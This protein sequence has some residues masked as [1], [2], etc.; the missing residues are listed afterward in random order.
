MF[1]CFYVIFTQSQ[2]HGIYISKHI[3]LRT[4]NASEMRSQIAAADVVTFTTIFIIEKATTA[5]DDC[6]DYATCNMCD[7]NTSNTVSSSLSSPFWSQQRRHCC[8]SV[9]LVIVLIKVLAQICNV[10]TKKINKF[11][12]SDKK[13]VQCIFFSLSSHAFSILSTILYTTSNIQ[14]HTSLFDLGVSTSNN[15]TGNRSPQRLERAQ[16]YAS[17][18]CRDC[19]NTI[20]AN[21]P[22]AVHIR[23]TECL[24]R[25]SV[26]RTR[27]GHAAVTSSAPGSTAAA[28]LRFSSTT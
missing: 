17:L 10:N 3:M 7:N 26:G 16:R 12:S 4:M 19:V 25:T 5:Y 28:E 21:R 27:R 13:T 9:H 14:N 1:T 20:S 6:S 11:L 2:V 22:F 15:C 23:Q 8:K 18:P 24:D